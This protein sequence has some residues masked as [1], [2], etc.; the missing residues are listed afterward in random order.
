M[1][2]YLSVPEASSLS[3]I[4]RFVLW[5]KIRSGKLAAWRPSEHGTRI[6]LIDL[7]PLLPPDV[8]AIMPADLNGETARGAI[9][10]ILAGLP[11]AAPAPA[12]VAAATAAPAP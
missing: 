3:G 5:E 8:R 10:G 12:P 2:I 6:N 11:S 1:A 7:A 4:S 9:A